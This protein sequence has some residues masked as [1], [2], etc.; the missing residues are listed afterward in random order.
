MHKQARLNLFKPILC[1]SKLGSIYLGLVSACASYTVPK[2]IDFPRYDMKSSRENM[3]LRE[4]V[5][6]VSGFPLQFMLYRGNLDCFSN[7]VCSIYLV[8]VCA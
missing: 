2:V 6:V 8:L 7:S 5:H 3:I 1:M 4:I